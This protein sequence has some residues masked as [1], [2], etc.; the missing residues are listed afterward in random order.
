MSAA[1]WITSVAL[2]LVLFA[3]PFLRYTHVGDATAAHV[4][5]RPRNGGVLRMVGDYHL[6]VRRR[7]G[8][9]EV[10]ASDAVRAPLRARAGWVTFGQ[11]HREPLTAAADRLTAPDRFPGQELRVEIELPDA[12]VLS[13]DFGALQPGR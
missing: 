13:W 1:S 10:F 2:G 5:H 4:D 9:V 3:V 8:R 7:L 11:T 12:T 6:E